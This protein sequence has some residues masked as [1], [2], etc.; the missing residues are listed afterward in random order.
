L[1]LFIAGGTG[2]IGPHVIERFLEDG[3][4]VKALV[5]N[6]RKIETLPAGVEII[7][8]DPTQPGPWQAKASECQV[9]VNLTGANIFARWTPEYKK[10]ILRTRL[11]STKRVVEALA[12]G[13]GRILLNASAVGYYG[14]HRGEEEVSEES[15]AGSDFLAEVCR[16]WEAEA[17]TGEKFGLR[18][19]LMR[20]GVVLGRGG[21]ALSKMLPAFKFGLG[22]PIGSGKQWFPW[23]HVKDVAEAA[24]FLVKRDDLRGPFNFVSPGIVR[25]KEFAKLLGKALG[26]P[27]FLPV[28]AF[29]LH[30]LFGEMARVVTGGVKARPRRLL[31]AG[32]RFLFPEALEALREILGKDKTG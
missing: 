4:D 19:C 24:L 17:L 22:G 11:E 21:G 23:I 13:N 1:K 3:W 7:L 15:P 27:A 6:E 8:G 32:Y 14:A 12:S 5:R 25:Q 28:P 18:V 10:E 31:E 26:R 29:V 20:F 9:A 30:L 2:F 16:A